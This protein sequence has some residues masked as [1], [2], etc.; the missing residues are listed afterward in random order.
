MSGPKSF[1]ELVADPTPR[2]SRPFGE[3]QDRLAA[4]GNW[5]KEASNQGSERR[6]AGAVHSVGSF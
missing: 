6:D 3:A 5:A 2:G 4:D 1:G